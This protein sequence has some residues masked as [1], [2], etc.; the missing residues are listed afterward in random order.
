LTFLLSQ[1]K[2]QKSEKVLIFY[3]YLHIKFSSFSQLS[4]LFSA[5]LLFWKFDQQLLLTKS[6]SLLN[7]FT[8]LAFWA[9]A[10][11][12]KL[13]QARTS[14]KKFASGFLMMAK[15]SG[16]KSQ[17]TDEQDEWLDQAKVEFIKL[18]KSNNNGLFV[19]LNDTSYGLY[20]L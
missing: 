15:H 2:K 1:V 19:P 7:F 4:Q 5:F 8:F 3:I 13:A 18:V 17:Y 6:R 11:S 14:S 12:C 10:S 16:S 9:C 20:C